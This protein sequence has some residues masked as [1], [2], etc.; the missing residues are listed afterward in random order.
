M[1]RSIA[2]DG[3]NR[4]LVAREDARSLQTLHRIQA[5]YNRM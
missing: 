3:N 1:M 4:N 5:N 2:G